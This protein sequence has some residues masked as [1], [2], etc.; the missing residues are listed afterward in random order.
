[1]NGCQ[2]LEIEKDESFAYDKSF[3]DDQIYKQPVTAPPISNTEKNVVVV[4][5][6]EFNCILC[7]CLYA[8]GEAT[9]NNS[10]SQKRKTQACT[11]CE[12]FKVC[13][14]STFMFMYVLSLTVVCVVLMI[15]EVLLDSRV[16]MVSPILDEV[17]AS[18]TDV[19]DEATK[20]LSE[21]LHWISFTIICLFV[22]EIVCR[23]LARKMEVFRNPIALC[24]SAVVVTS[25]T[26]N[27]T[28]SLAVGIDSPW[29]AISLLIAFRLVRVYSL[30]K[31][32][33]QR[34]KHYYMNRLDVLHVDHST[35]QLSH[36]K[37]KKQIADKDFEIK[38]LMSHLGSGASGGGGEIAEEI[39]RVVETSRKLKRSSTNDYESRL[40]RAIENS[41]KQEYVSKQGIVNYA[42]IPPSDTA[43]AYN[44]NNSSLPNVVVHHRRDSLQDC[45]TTNEPGTS[46][47][48]STVGVEAS[49]YGVSML[50][51]NNSNDN[52]NNNNN[53]S[54]LRTVNCV[55]EQN[56]GD[57]CSKPSLYGALETKKANQPAAAAAGD[58]FPSKKFVKINPKKLRQKEKIS[59][60]GEKS[61][62]IVK[63]SED[64]SSDDDDE[65]I[66]S[67]S[68]SL[69]RDITRSGT[70]TSTTTGTEGSDHGFSSDVLANSSPDENLNLPTPPPPPPVANDLDLPLKD[71]GGIELQN[72][73]MSG[74]ESLSSPY[75]SSNQNWL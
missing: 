36:M 48:K 38:Q 5:E 34:V 53:S 41:K 70:E 35:L 71:S 50:L 2:V 52:N 3:T 1:M 4:E 8:Q 30:L 32:N 6:T 14:S 39:Q 66:E 26:V 61:R 68:A 43:T 11:N 33:H 28:T 58:V 27:L 69:R 37:L 18:T 47:Q 22:I 54:G 10:G 9:S 65:G 44:N 42:Y 67:A 23:V 15:F 12:Q 56:Y 60:V 19:A 7:C 16:L 21:I 75:N 49:S 51:S 17:T 24:D 72:R 74:S 45:S 25:F 31:V 13:L 62:W 64:L 63:G 73:T 20:H 46:N 55:V 40:Q 29:D 59:L 57:G